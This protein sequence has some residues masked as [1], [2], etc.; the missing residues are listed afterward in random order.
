MEPIIIGKNAV[1]RIHIEWRGYKNHEFVDIPTY[2]LGDAGDRKPTHKGTSGA[3]DLW[4]EFRAAI[5]EVVV[6]ESHP[7]TAQER[8]SFTSGS[9]KA[10]T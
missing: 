4:P 6:N 5:V 8:R 2:D 9:L 1:E 3:L 7:A 10:G